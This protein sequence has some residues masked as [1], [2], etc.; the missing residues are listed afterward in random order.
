[1][2]GYLHQLGVDERLRDTVSGEHRGEDVR[3][4]E[5]AG[6]VNDEHDHKSR[7]SDRHLDRCRSRRW[8]SSQ[9]EPRPQRVSPVDGPGLVLEIVGAK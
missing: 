6:S 2:V 5:L 4:D 1:M 3:C 9:V 7:V 8:T